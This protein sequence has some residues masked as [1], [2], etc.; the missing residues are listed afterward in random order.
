MYTSYPLSWTAGHK[1]SLH[2]T[3]TTGASHRYTGA[4]HEPTGSRAM[5]ADGDSS[6]IIPELPEGLHLVEVQA[7]GVTIMY[8]HAEVLPSPIGDTG[9][10]QTYSVL[11][12]HLQVTISGGAPGPKGD[13]GDKGEKGD[14]GDKGETGARGATGPTGPIGPQ[15]PQGPAG[16]DGKDGTDGGRAAML[17]LEE[18][19]WASEEGTAALTTHA[20][21]MTPEHIPFG[22]FKKLSLRCRD[23]NPNYLYGSPVYLRID[24]TA[25]NGEDWELLG[26]SKAAVQQQVGDY[27]TWEFEGIPIHNRMLRIAPVAN[28][29]DPYVEG[30]PIT[31]GLLDFS[32]NDGST[33]DSLPY[34]PNYKITASAPWAPIEH[35]ADTTAHL[36]DEEHQALKNLIDNPPTGA[37]FDVPYTYDAAKHSFAIGEKATTSSGIYS[38]ALGQS[39]RAFSNYSTALGYGASASGTSC[40]ALGNYTSASALYSMA[41]GYG[42]RAS[43]DYSTALGYY[44]IIK[45]RATLVLGTRSIP[46]GASTQL[47]LVA[48]GSELSTRCCEGKAALGYTVDDGSGN[49]QKSGWI[50]LEELC[51]HG[52]F[53]PVIK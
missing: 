34:L 3:D 25:L 36:D 13:K 17:A 22:S 18:T 28:I 37:G 31:L 10:E 27:Q 29:G 16:K 24:E 45:E 38:T 26:F 12:D 23:N 6:L 52:E 40:M 15:G 43:G 8:Q 14:K 30:G 35:V 33:C 19:T 41:L 50:A 20:I 2:F 48:E 11:V 5:T 44:A 9:L 32:V 51:T 42:A 46:T 49:I 53:S 47:Y 4:V 39:A 7:D 1:A 21:F